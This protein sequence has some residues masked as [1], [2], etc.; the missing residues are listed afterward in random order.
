MKNDKFIRLALTSAILAS[1]SPL[2]WA[3]GSAQDAGQAGGQATTPAAQTATSKAR[4][5]DQSKK[6]QTLQ[7]VVVTA[8]ATG[9]KKLDASYNIVTANR[10]E[11][12]HSNPLSTADLLKI[13][14]GIWPE[15]TGGQTGANIEIAGFPG[16]GDAP[17]FTNM[18][19]GTP[20]YGMP[21]LSFMDSS[22]LLR[23]DDT[24]QRVE[25]VQGGPG[26][27]FGP[28]QMGAT[29][30]FILRQGTATPS[31]DVGLTYGDE[32]MW[33]LDGFYG[34]KV[35]E[36]WYASI[37]GFWRRSDG[38]RDP[39]D[40]PSD[41]GGQLT[42]TLSHDWDNGSF[43]LWARRLDD[44]NQFIVPI[45]LIQ[46]SGD[47]F[48]GFPGLDP[49]TGTYASGAI[50][51]VQVPNPL[52]Y[53]ENADLA[54]GRGAQMN[55]LGGS[56][57]AEVGGWTLY[58]RFLFT[59]GDL[60]TNALFS[61]PNPK[62]LGYYLYGCNMAQPTGYCDANNNPVDSDTLG[63]SPSQNISATLPDGS[64]VPLDQSV[65]HQGWW[66]IQKHL[67]GFNNDFRISREI[68]D[69]NTLTAG[70]YLARY[71]DHDNW[72][73]GNQMLML[74]QSNTKPIGLTY[75]QNGQTIV[76]ASPM[77]FVDFNDNYNIV[78][79]GTGTNK[80]FYLSD[81]WT[82]GPWLLQAAGRVENIN[83]DQRTCNQS[84]VDLDGDP[85]TL[86]DNTTPV[87][88]G[89][90]DY[91][92]YEKTH[93]S[94][95]AGANYQFNDHMSA[96]V[97]F[98]TG[99]HFD[100]FDN[101]IRGTGGNFAPMQKIRNFEGGFKYQ[102][103]VLFVDVSVYHRLF[104]GLTYTQTGPNGQPIPG[105]PIGIYGA[106]SKGLDLNATWS[107]TENLSL[108]LLGIYMDGHYSHYNGC[109]P[110]TDINGNPQCASIDGAPLQ[111]QPKVRYMFTPMYKL[112]TSWGS[113]TAWVT[114]THVG[115]HYQ[116]ISALQPLGTYQTLDGGI[117][118]DV[119]Q[120][121]QFSLL[122]TNLTNEL[123]LTEGNSRKFGVNTG[124]G[125]VIMA[126]PLFG[127]EVNFQVKYK[128]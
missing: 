94:F 6:V 102:S 121:W 71:T 120:N 106:N 63:Y 124:I 11:I 49:L 15:S 41:N 123:G 116:D 73:L 5:Q 81:S 31:G 69:G 27:V 93:P 75:Q 87:C 46:G 110:Y 35:A 83:V 107:P 108:K 113:I 90:W 28:G 89:T 84:K 22:S 68:F 4:Q 91:E 86:Y 38:V 74:N 56:Y 117:V 25:I 79:A 114:Y 24:I 59:N 58:D 48:H 33:R 104:T 125:G 109:A 67:K 122:G 100:D 101:G 1:L 52:G 50:Q 45:S 13:S 30:N 65:I 16:G 99:G 88:N 57:D 34:F 126:R 12:K 3:S 20:L 95:T 115:Q 92:H 76:V 40:F 19:N 61:G 103:D 37:G 21:S 82:V 60:P 77:G 44:K 80:A 98:N 72:S 96:Y 32:G 128:F 54:N 39:R 66:Y 105:A 36:G 70:L 2:V 118:A 17:F 23:L 26:A 85:N 29:A 51:H 97:R 127:R 119:G 111:R 53:L 7:T 9:V 47:S 8:S 42:A 62:P 78:E 112:P 55:F 43:M 10:E 18:V 14:P 64:A